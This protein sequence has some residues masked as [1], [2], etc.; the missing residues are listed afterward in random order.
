MSSVFFSTWHFFGCPWQ[1]WKKAKFARDKKNARDNFPHRIFL[2]VTQK[3][4]TRDKN[5]KHCPWQKNI[6]VKFL[7]DNFFFSRLRRDRLFH[8]NFDRVILVTRDNFWKCPWHFF[9]SRHLPVT[10]ARD[11]FEKNNPWHFALARD[12][13]QKMQ[14]SRA[15]RCHVDKKTL[16]RVGG[17]S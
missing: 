7:G 4:N 5:E 9:K 1:F 17:S 12:N 6:P 16:E 11:I 3:K 14:M 8:F 2:P 10:L 13:S 15:K